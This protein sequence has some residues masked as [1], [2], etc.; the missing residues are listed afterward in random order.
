[1]PNY[2]SMNLA[3]IG[4][5]ESVKKAVEFVK[6]ENSAFDF[7]KIVPRPETFDKYDTTNHPFGE[8]LV[9]GE[10]KDRWRPESEDNPIVTPKLI[11]EYQNASK[12]QAEKYGVVGWYDWDVKYWGTKWN[13]CDVV[14]DGITEDG[15]RYFLT[16]AWSAPL[17]VLKRLS[18]LFPDLVIDF[19]YADEDMGYNTGQGNFTNGEMYADFPDGGSDEAMALYFKTNGGADLFVRTK[20]GEWRWADDVD[21]EDIDEEATEKFFEEIGV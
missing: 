10:L 13:A 18:E 5:E 8:G 17:P 19:E 7:N 4:N 16:T 1:M 15:A 14:F 20:D 3:L 12:E 9:L 21:E 11:A 6:G 2:V